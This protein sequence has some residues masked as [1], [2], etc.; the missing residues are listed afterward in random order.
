MK[1]EFCGKEHNGEYS[2]RFCCQECARKY[3]SSKCN[4][5]ESK[6]G[7]CI[8]CGRDILIP[9]NASLKFCKCDDCKNITRVFVK[10]NN[11]ETTHDKRNC[12]ITSIKFEN[13]ENCFFFK[14]SLCNGNLKGIVQRF[15]NISNIKLFEFDE[16][17]LGTTKVFDEYM[18]IKN[19]LYTLYYE[20][21]MSSEDIGKLCGKRIEDIVRKFFHIKFRNFSDS[22]RL[23]FDQGKFDLPQNIES[24]YKTEW[25][26][27][28]DGK[29][30]FLRSSYESDF[31]NELDKYK[32]EYEVES[33]KIKYYDSERK[34]YRLAI[35][36]F[37]LPKS[38]TIVE[39]KSNWT[40]N[41]QE[42]KDKV[43]SYKNLGYKFKLILDHKEVDLEML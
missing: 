24:F 43:K 31:A 21:N 28:W 17:T 12:K 37:Y 29:E 40:L 7:K 23:A 42:M 36:D 14:E 3:S 8:K 34:I 11:G 22:V 10:R 26:K 30:F 41:I 18:R 32:I 9:K 33:L 39:I 1:C 35:P 6:P 27:T 16:S 2:K 38:N 13:C 15:N 20:Q 25:H 5:H 4:R 19:L